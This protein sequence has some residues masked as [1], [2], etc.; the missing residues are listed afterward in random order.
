MMIMMMIIC[1]ARICSCWNS[2][3]IALWKSNKQTSKKQNNKERKKR[4]V[5]G[6]QFEVNLSLWEHWVLQVFL[7]SFLRIMLSQSNGQT[8]PQ[9]G[10]S[11][12]KLTPK[13]FCFVFSLGLHR[14]CEDEI[15]WPQTTHW[16]VAGY[17]CP[18][19]LEVCAIHATVRK[20]PDFVFYII[21]TGSQCSSR[22]M[23]EMW[24]DLL[25]RPLSSCSSVLDSLR[26]QWLL[27]WRVPPTAAAV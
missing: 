13:C 10:C 5:T 2:M 12:G 16:R 22:R 15:W 9:C 6:A 7:K 19:V 21:S 4:K 25:V 18:K 17:K 24:S 1:T 23:G 11:I 26:S 14:G 3:F 8:V 27:L 20:R